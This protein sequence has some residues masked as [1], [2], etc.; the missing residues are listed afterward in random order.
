[1]DRL[2]ETMQRLLAN[3]VSPFH[4]YTYDR[5]NW[6]N[7]MLGLVGPRGVGK[8]THFLQHIKESG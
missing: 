5:I 3:T 2:Y 8:T 6:D 7:R 4:R 1:M